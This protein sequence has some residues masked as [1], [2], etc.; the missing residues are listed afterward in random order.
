M[1]LMRIQ[2]AVN[3]P[4]GGCCAVRRPVRRSVR[5]C[6]G[7]WA[8]SAAALVGGCSGGEETGT[9]PA[10]AGE[11]PVSTERAAD[12]APPADAGPWFTEITE[13]VGLDFVHETG[14]TGQFYLPE[15]MC[16]GVAI[17][18]YDDDGRLDIY[19]VNGNSSPDF[20][21]REDE[22]VNRLYRQG[23]DG[24][25]TDVTE[26]SGLGDGGYG[27]GVA[28]GDFDND[29]D[30][31][32]YASNYGA[33]RLYRC[34]GD[35]TFEDVTE[36]AGIDV[37]NW[38]ASAAFVDF[39]GDGYLDLYVTRYVDHD[40]PHGCSGRAGRLDYCAPQVFDPVPDVLLH[41]NG[42]GTFTDVSDAAGIT[43]V[44]PSAGL[45]I[46][47]E[48][49]TDDGWIDIY[50]SNDGDANY[51]WINQ[52]D[53]TFEEAGLMTGSALNVHGQTEASMGLIACD[54]DG[55]LDLDLFMTHQS[56]ET[57]TLYENLGDGRG[58]AD[59]TGERGLGASSWA[60]TG[61]GT[62]AFDVELD[63]DEDLVIVGG[64]VRLGDPWPGA[65]VEP[66]WDRLAEPN[67]FYLNDG[68]GKFNLACEMA[69]AICGPVEVSRG[70]S[71]ADID[72]DGDLDVLVANAQGPARLFRNDAPRRG[73]WLSVR[74]VD[75]E[76][77]RDAIGAQV[78]AIVGERR[79][80][81][82]ISYGFSY[83]SARAPIAHFGLGEATGVDAVEVRW[84]DGE[85][86]RFPNPG[87]DRAVVLRR[88]TGG[89]A[90]MLA[91]EVAG[92]E[93]AR[94]ETATATG[95][96]EKEVLRAAG[97]VEIP[98]LDTSELEPRV[99]EL[100]TETYEAAVNN[101]ES[102]EAWWTFGSAADSHRL[103]EYSVPAYRKAVQLKPDNFKYVYN[104]GVALG[105]DPRGDAGECLA[106]LAEASR[107]EPDFAPVW[108]RLGEAH[109][110]KGAM[111]EARAAFE[112]ALA[113]D[114][115]LD[116]ARRGLGQTLLVQGEIDAAVEL[117]EDVARR[118]PEDGP[119]AGV[120]AQ[121]YGRRGDRD[122]ATEAGALARE[123]G[124]DLTYEDPVRG[125]A[126]SLGVSAYICEQRAHDLMQDGNYV[127]AMR[128]LRIVVEV[129]PDDPQAH[130]KL[131]DAAFMAGRPSLAL[132]HLDEAVRL[133]PNLPEAYQVR[134][135]ALLAVRRFDEAVASYRRYQALRPADRR[136]MW[137]LAGALAQAGR[138]DEALAQFERAAAEAPPSA[139]GRLNWGVALMQAGDLGT[140]SERFR[141]VLE[142]QPDNV[143]AHCNLGIVYERTGRMESAVEHYREAARLDPR[144]F[145]AR[146]L[147]QLGIGR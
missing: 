102:A 48:D 100:L 93:P 137:Q 120:L 64:R 17:F 141:E 147:A 13:E 35:G 128:N 103:Y 133:D 7:A 38:S 19:L 118:H 61:F 101:P 68:T 52:G 107:L 143:L 80:M 146:R 126:L 75:P 42:D 104:L 135:A 94:V 129:R 81:R 2:V 28:I 6:G 145:G 47:C 83:C 31:D 36:A 3:R 136:I 22:H 63:G 51:L 15:I 30:A 122:R 57:N 45:G 74:A 88:G 123:H 71:V 139:S 18:D 67:L 90:P 85:I 95:G 72:Q 109:A 4:H 70:L 46:I 29:G 87:I 131:G 44:P 5:L 98:E 110:R 37:G 105:E 54:I 73:R 86:E 53:G 142:A 76:F 59:V 23:A 134:G 49:L 115:D 96:Q 97:P 69:E 79:F 27:M 26:S 24:R 16:S 12:P 25:F 58:F 39:D 140:A 124:D 32:V 33:D 144:S 92:P 121:A 10:P 56:S 77:S 132:T 89:A 60:Y 65:E 66:P 78:V 1:S 55:D 50:V 14:A 21:E 119:T 108:L 112:R 62:A 99:A 84:P 8:L 40:P 43:A 113:L 34:R 106:Y 130:Y 111:D 41:N 127:E 11:R 114:A 116:R 117:L 138:L 20:G 91:G 82:T 9:A 125:E